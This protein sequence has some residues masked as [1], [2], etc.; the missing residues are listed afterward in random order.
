MSDKEATG[1]RSLEQDV[2]SNSSPADGASENADSRVVKKS[3]AQ[4]ESEKLASTST[5]LSAAA[6][7]TSAGP[8]FQQNQ[9]SQLKEQRPP[10][11]D[12]QP[13]PQQQHQQRPPKMDHAFFGTDVIDDVV[14]TIGEFLFEHCHHPN[15]E[16]EAKLGVLIDKKTGRRIDLPVRNEV[17]LAP[18]GRPTWYQF[19]SDMTVD[20]HAHFNKTL[21]WRLEQTRKTEPKERQIRYQHTYEIDQFFVG[22]GNSGGKVRVTRDQNTKEVIPNGIVKKERIADLDIFSPRNAFDFRVS[23]NIETPIPAPAQGSAPLFERQ[24]NRVSYRH[25]NF[26]IDLTQVKQSNTPNAGGGRNNFSQMNPALLNNNLST[27]DL[28]H[29]LEIEFVHPE[30][31]VRER[32]VRISGGGRQPDRFMDIVSQF[33]N[34]VR[35]MV[36]RGNIQQQQQQQQRP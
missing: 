12:H 32:D 35:G 21:N 14:R 31:L 25:N 18:Q 2:A 27:L 6:S 20:Q 4:D 16:I 11:A 19:S 24:K 13:R 7:A 23:V 1:K 5:P 28:T 9:P 26:K 22:S 34:N 17:V 3:R 15:V 33:V 29:E 30:E 10:A 8:P 36:V